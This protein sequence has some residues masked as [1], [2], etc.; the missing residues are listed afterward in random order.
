MGFVLPS[1]LAAGVADWTCHRATNIESTTGT[2][3]SLMHLL[4]LSE[5]A[6]PVLA[7]LF[8]EITSPVIALMSAS[9]MPCRDLLGEHCG[10]LL[11]FEW[12][13]AHRP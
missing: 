7:G 13:T 12:L 1:W 9:L 5:A 11:D 8:L 3:E 2:K 10:E 4:M 6:V